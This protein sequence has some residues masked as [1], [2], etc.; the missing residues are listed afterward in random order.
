MIRLPPAFETSRLRIRTPRLHDANALFSWA[1]DPE[2]TRFLGF[3]PHR[4]T[5]DS[6]A[7]LRRWIKAWAQSQGLVAHCRDLTYLIEY[8][9]IPIGSLSVHAGRL[10]LEIGYAL[11]REVWG[12]GFMPEAV[13]TLTETLLALG[14]V[15]V[16]AT[17][18]VDNHRSQRVLEKTGFVREGRLE[19]YFYFPNLGSFG[20]GF[21][22]ARTASKAGD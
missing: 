9:G 20:D 15:R 14:G 17:A 18:H 21:L 16:M 6:L 1:S 19:R 5:D 7:V 8:R 2:V 12:K 3:R 13:A 22:Y 11:S 4:S 10:G